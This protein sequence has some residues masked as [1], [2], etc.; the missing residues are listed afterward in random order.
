MKNVPE[1]ELE[2]QTQ[3]DYEKRHTPKFEVYQD[4][5]GYYNFCLKAKNG[6]I[7]ANGC[8]FKTIES[9]LHSISRIR[10]KV[11]SPIEDYE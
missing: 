8:G 4:N 1:A 7:I 3:C 5:T 9:C 11:D 6:S 10:K 2:D